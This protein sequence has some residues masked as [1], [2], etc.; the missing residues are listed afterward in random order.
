MTC[1]TAMILAML[2]ITALRPGGSGRDRAATRLA[3]PRP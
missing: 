2:T 3:G 1:T